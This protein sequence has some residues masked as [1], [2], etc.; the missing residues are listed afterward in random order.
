MDHIGGGRYLKVFGATAERQFG[1]ERSVLRMLERH[2]AIP[3][4]RI[5]AV[6]ERTQIPP[7]LILT[8]GKT[9]PKVELHPCKNSRLAGFRTWCIL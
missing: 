5:V 2:N 3:A 6:G 4:P 9:R 1:V 8:E 7:Y